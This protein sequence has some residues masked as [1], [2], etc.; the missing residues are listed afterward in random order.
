MIIFAGHDELTKHI[1]MKHSKFIH[2][3]SR[4]YMTPSVRVRSLIPCFPVCLQTSN[5]AVAEDYE[6]ENIWNN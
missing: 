5:G 2:P 4:E 3:G 6:E 1:D